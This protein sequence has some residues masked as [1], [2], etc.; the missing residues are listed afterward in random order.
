MRQNNYDSWD[1]SKLS[2]LGESAER[3]PPKKKTKPKGKE[4]NC[5]THALGLPDSLASIDSESIDTSE[6]CYPCVRS[7]LRLH[8]YLA[9]PGVYCI[10]NWLEKIIGILEGRTGPE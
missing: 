10:P 8:A 1:A 9:A 2:K 5:E 6:S 4:T 7:R 3:F